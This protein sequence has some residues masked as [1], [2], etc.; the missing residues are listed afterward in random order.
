MRCNRA[1]GECSKSHD[2]SF[3]FGSVF[4][5]W[6]EVLCGHKNE[7]SSNENLHLENLLEPRDAFTTKFQQFNCGA[8]QL[9]HLKQILVDSFN[10]TGDCL[11]SA[12]LVSTGCPSVRF[13]RMTRVRDSECQKD[14]QRWYK[15]PRA[16]SFRN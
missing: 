11:A 2:R 5:E 14:S 1:R 9:K 7:T 4:G 8:D 6:T 13:N 10:E 16:K 15:G 3:K 12:L